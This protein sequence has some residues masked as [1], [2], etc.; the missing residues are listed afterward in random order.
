MGE[1]SARWTP[2]TAWPG[3]PGFTIS[4]CGCLSDG[5]E[6]DQ[7]GDSVPPGVGRRQTAPQGVDDGGLLPRGEVR[8]CFD[9]E[10]HRLHLI[11][12]KWLAVHTRRVGGSSPST[13][14]HPTGK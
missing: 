6:A 2:S 13:A 1:E 12:R 3:L 8:V 11:R 5:L 7:D 14:T 9:L 4:S 10:R